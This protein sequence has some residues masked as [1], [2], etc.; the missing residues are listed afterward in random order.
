M[1]KHF[2]LESMAVSLVKPG[3]VLA[4]SRKAKCIMQTTGEDLRYWPS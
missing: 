4:P 3:N 1:D 2:N